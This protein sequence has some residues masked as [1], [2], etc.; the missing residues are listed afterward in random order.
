MVDANIRIGSSSL[1]FFPPPLIL[2]SLLPSS[3]LPSSPPPFFPPPLPPLPPE[4]FGFDGL[5]HVTLSGAVHHGNK[6]VEV[7]LQTFAPGY[8]TNVRSQEQDTVVV[9]LKGEGALRFRPNSTDQVSPAPFASTPFRAN[10][11]VIIPRNTVHQLVNSGKKR[12]QFL[13]IFGKPPIKF[14]EFTSWE[15]AQG[16]KVFPGP[17]DR[18]CLPGSFFGGHRAPPNQDV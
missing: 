9:V 17:F 3:F 7:W 14:R 15:E 12:L 1:P 16:K 10:S 11:T 8:A 6:G 13:H 2:Y 5:V 18:K 4:N